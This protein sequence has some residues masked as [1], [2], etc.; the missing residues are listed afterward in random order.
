MGVGSQ[1]S[2]LKAFFFSTFSHF[3]V[4]VKIKFTGNRITSRIFI[5]ESVEQPFCCEDGAGRDFLKL[6]ACGRCTGFE[7]LYGLVRGYLRWAGQG[8]PLPHASSHSSAYPQTQDWKL[9]L[10]GVGGRMMATKLLPPSHHPAK[11]QGSVLRTLSGS[12]WPVLTHPFKC[13]QGNAWWLRL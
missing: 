8:S 4:G 12:F 7:S 2:N 9:P 11:G 5:R 3:Q 10:D 13:G 6:S 1:H